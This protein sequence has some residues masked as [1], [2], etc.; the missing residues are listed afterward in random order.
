MELKSETVE[1]R[2]GTKITVTEENWDIGTR[3]ELMER[4]LRESKGVTPEEYARRSLY[5]RMAACSSGDVPTEAEARQWPSA[6]LDKWYFAAKR[7][8]PGWFAAF[9]AAVDQAQAQ[10]KKLQKRHK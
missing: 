6:E 1:F 10:K 3:L 7:I 9:D 5:N 4:E 2:D 8:N